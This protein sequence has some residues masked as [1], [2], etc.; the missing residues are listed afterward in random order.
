LNSDDDKPR[1]TASGFDA[2]LGDIAR[3]EPRTP[4]EAELLIGE[5]VDG[6]YH[7]DALLGRGGMGAVYRATHVGTGRAVAF[8]VLVPEL[9]ANDGAV[10]RFKREARAAGQMRHPNVVDVTDFGFAERGDERLAYLVMELLRGKTLRAVLDAEGRLPV[11]VAIR[12]LDQVCSAVAEAHA[13]GILHRDLKPENIHLE[14]AAGG[15][16]VKVLDFG[17]AKLLHGAADV[18]PAPG[19]ASARS[20]DHVS[21]LAATL[22]APTTGSGDAAITRAGAAV[23]TPLYMSPE[24]WRGETVDARTDVYSLGVVAYEMLAGGPPFTGKDRWIALEHAESAPPALAERAPAVPRRIASVVEAA[25]AKDPAARPPSAAAFAAALHA[26]TETTGRLLRRSIALAVDHYALLAR[27]S[28]VATIPP[29][30]LAAIGVGSALLGRAGVVSASVD[31]VVGDV[32]FVAALLSVLLLYMPVGG[33]LV[34]LVA[35]LMA[36]GASTRSP[37][38]RAEVWRTLWASLPSGLV[39]MVIGMVA[40]AVLAAPIA[41]LAHLHGLSKQAA[42]L[43][44]PFTT[45]ASSAAS[46]P[47]TVYAAVVVIER[48]SGL[49]PMRRSATLLRSMWRAAFGVQ[50]FYAVLGQAL[51]QLG[52]L[53]L[54]AAAT[55]LLPVEAERTS[56]LLLWVTSAA[57]MPFILVPFA[58]LY[59]RAREAEGKAVAVPARGR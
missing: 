16:H 33:L 34:P 58:L 10:E 38:P 11:D 12:V 23:G 3:A 56:F 49:A 26:G 48:A 17:I 44:L 19:S 5:V 53:V 32:T 4:A 35:D 46:A 21:G 18:P 9:T 57:L 40:S 25:L 41:V 52:V 30:A 50:L 37:P 31:L 8:K 13:L 1:G 29:M 43:C 55:S 28:A 6:K 36:S 54:R 14:V 20:P 15:Y 2:L 47:F 39:L 27:R 51:P 24:Q 7:V 45:A 59:L 22:A 42:L